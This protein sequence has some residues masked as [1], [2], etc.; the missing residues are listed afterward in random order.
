MTG[1]PVFNPRYAKGQPEQWIEFR[2]R[3]K[4]VAAIHAALAATLVAL[5]VEERG[6]VGSGMVVEAF[7]QVDAALRAAG[8]TI[9]GLPAKVRALLER[10]VM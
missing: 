7:Q 2:L 4:H 5:Q 1:E 9:E 10:N 6:T 8:V 3:V